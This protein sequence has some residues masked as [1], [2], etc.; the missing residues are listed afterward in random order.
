MK[1]VSKVDSNGKIVY[2]S[3]IINDIIESAL[4]SVE[5][6]A[7][8]SPTNSKVNRKYRKGI[9]VDS[10]G[11]NVYI[12]VFVKLQYNVS[13]RDVSYRIQQSIKDTL[14][15]MTDFN[16]KDINVHVIDVELESPSNIDK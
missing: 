12:D 13:V 5:G 10:V 6:V 3:E 16:I 15:S 11:D 9:R 1:V 4:Y 14:E 8:L 7:K 2:S